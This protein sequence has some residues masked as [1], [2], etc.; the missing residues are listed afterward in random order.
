MLV[1]KFW[2][3]EEL[4]SYEILSACRTKLSQRIGG[5]KFKKF[6]L[7]DKTKCCSGP[8]VLFLRADPPGILL[9]TGTNLIMDFELV[10]DHPYLHQIK[11]IYS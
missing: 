2:I 8:I 6:V 5:R 10:F 9:S 3:V 4:H 1:S 11:W 7:R